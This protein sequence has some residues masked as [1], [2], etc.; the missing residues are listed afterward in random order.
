M[1][2]PITPLQSRDT[3]VDLCTDRLSRDPATRAKTAI[4]AKS[5]ATGGDGAVNIGAG[6]ARINAHL[7]NTMSKP[8]A[9]ECIVSKVT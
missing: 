6:E 1:I 9:Q 3:V 5:T 7:L 2:A 8:L 4:V